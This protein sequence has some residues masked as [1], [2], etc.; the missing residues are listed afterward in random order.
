MSSADAQRQAVDMARQIIEGRKAASKSE[1]TYLAPL[2][3]EAGHTLT[4]V[5]AD[6]KAPAR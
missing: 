1:A 2:L 3:L 6:A 4:R 5:A